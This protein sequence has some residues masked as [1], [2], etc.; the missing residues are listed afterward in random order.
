MQDSDPACHQVYLLSLWRET[1]DAPWR[2][3][4]RQASAQERIG[5]A[6]LEA[7]ALFLLRLDDSRSQPS[8]L[9]KNTDD[10]TPTF[11]RETK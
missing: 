4:L 9:A 8:R 5:F 2:A 7:L 3:A 10:S 11:G 1:A 6:D